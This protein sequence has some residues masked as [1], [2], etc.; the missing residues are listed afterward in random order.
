V[1]RATARIQLGAI[2]GPAEVTVSVPELG[3]ATTVS[4][5]A[6]PGL[7]YTL[8]IAPQD[9]VVEVGAKFLS[10]SKVFDRH[11]NAR[12]EPVTLSDPSTN[13]TIQ[14]PQITAAAPG[15]GAVAV[16]ADTLVDVLRVFV[17]PL[18]HVT[19]LTE[20]ALVTFETDGSIAASTSLSRVVDP[21]TAD[22]SP[23]GEVMVA[24]DNSGG[25]MRLILPD[26]QTPC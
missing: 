9:T 10:R 11:G 8:V 19:G 2:A 16:R 24:D 13:L 22:W 14:G 17:G 6:T 18:S 7:A 26:G 4:Y 25:P 15:R 1:G 23:D 5:T 12:D 3:Y 21:F 20:T